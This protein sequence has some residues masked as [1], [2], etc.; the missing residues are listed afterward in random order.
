VGVHAENNQIMQYLIK[1]LK[2][3]GRTDPLAHVETRPNIAEAESIS[4]IILLA[5]AAGAKV[6]IYHMS[7]KEGVNLVKAGKERGVDVTAETG[8]H[9]LLMEDKDMLKLKSILKMNPPVRSKD[10]ADRLWWGLLNGY[11][12]CIATDHSP[13]TVEEKTNDNIWN[14]IP[15][16][17]GV[18][19]SVPLMLTQV[20]AG[21]LTLNQYVKLASENPAKVWDM[22]PQKGSVRIGSDGDLT[23]VDMKKESV[24]KSANLHS[25]TKVT[26]FDG[27]KVKGMP[28]YTIVR[29]KVVMKDGQLV[30]THAGKIVIPGK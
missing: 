5:E 21:R 13:H 22:Y 20:N 11:V 26:P 23:I 25:K 10:N 9:Y 27:W 17:T 3:A 15:G 1:K 19:T 28:I 18:E 4:K 7:S 24:L 6:H 14:A 12:D 2:A 8:P 30:G 29:G 16:F